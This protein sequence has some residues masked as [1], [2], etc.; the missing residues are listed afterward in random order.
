V[1]SLWKSE[2]IILVYTGD[3]HDW[4]YCMWECGV[5]SHPSSPDTKIIVFKCGSNLPS[6]F[7][8]QV[9]VN[10]HK[11]DDIQKFTNDLFTSVDFF[12]NSTTAIWGGSPNSPNL[13]K[14][15]SVF[16][17]E[18]QPVLPLEKELVSE[19]W[20]AYPFL[21]LQINLQKVEELIQAARNGSLQD[22]HNIILNESYISDSDK[23]CSQ[24]FNAMQLE[25]GMILKDLVE[26]WRENF[27]KSESMWAEVL[28][29]QILAGARW[30]F[31][32]PI[33]EVMEGIGLGE[34]RFAP[35]VNRVRKIPSKKCM[36]FDIYFYKFNTNS[37]LTNQIFVNPPSALD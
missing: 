8:G 34:I 30:T 6:L 35:M 24:L 19:E 26:M 28:C 4:S 12:P 33:W 31:P 16:F 25:S 2:V 21:Q 20:P 23:Y 22:A 13:V 18:L 29:D 7:N 36:Q 32:A 27:T 3:D 17:E 5:A 37:K 1:E 11:L 14:A 9:T 10:A 15:A